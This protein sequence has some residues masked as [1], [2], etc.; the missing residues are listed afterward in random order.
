VL[1]VAITLSAS[2][3]L[4]KRSEKN[5][6]TLFLNSIK[7]EIEENIRMLDHLNR[8]LLQPA[9][10]Y[11][12]YLMSN[13]K[14]SLNL[15]SLKYYMQWTVYDGSSLTFKT[16][17]FDMFKTSGNMR[18]VENKELLLSIWDLYALLVETKGFFDKS[19]EMKTEE[20][21]KYMFAYG[22]FPSDEDILKNPPLYD[23]YFNM[24]I[25]YVQ[26]NLYNRAM[27]SLQ[28]ALSFFVENE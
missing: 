26:I 10:K 17:A 8:V 16:N 19:S 11:S 24:P 20:I 23:I 14:N 21:R 9:K 27:T 13:D 5:D 25:P 2:Y 3:W 18:L 15:D 28:K 6:T 12:D 22:R 1:G 4:T 7:L